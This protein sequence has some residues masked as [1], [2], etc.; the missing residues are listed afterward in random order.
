VRDTP[1]I[2]MGDASASTPDGSGIPARPWQSR[3]GKSSAGAG[4]GAAL[5][6][7]AEDFL[8][9]G[10]FDRAPWLAVLFMGGIL[11][12][13]TLP[14]PL[15]W[16]AAMVAAGGYAV[17]AWQA[18][19]PLSEACERRVHLRQ[20]LLAGGLVFAAGIAVVGA[21]S[22]VAGEPP[23]AAPTAEVLHGAVLEREDEPA[24]G[25]IRLTLAVRLAG[26]GTATPA[27]QRVQWCGCEL[28]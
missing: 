21:R 12:W 17:A 5:A 7:R 2:P 3:S 9:A 23:I 19:P 22:E 27:A 11:T 13:F 28:G 16:L 26:D 10:G 18:W 20:A 8:A 4:Q 1:I 6:A 24:E 15:Y 25:R 14:G